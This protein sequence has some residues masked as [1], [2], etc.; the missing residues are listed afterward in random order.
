[1][2]NKIIPSIPKN[3]HSDNFQSEFRI[4]Q[5]EE[6]KLKPTKKSKSIIFAMISMCVSLMIIIIPIIWVVVMCNAG[7]DKIVTESS[8]LDINYLLPRRF[9]SSLDFSRASDKFGYQVDSGK[10]TE[11]RNPPSW[12]R[13]IGPT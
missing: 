8:D 2:K 1:M 12:L 13:K 10:I 6:N 9:G 5:S 7:D 11:Y 4:Q 3:V